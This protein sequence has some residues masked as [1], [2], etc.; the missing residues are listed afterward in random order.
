MLL[1]VNIA[2]SLRLVEFF[3]NS[4]VSDLSTSEDINL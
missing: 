2:L 1:Q 3:Q 4:L